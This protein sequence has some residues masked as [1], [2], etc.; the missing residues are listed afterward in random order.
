MKNW[1]TGDVFL[2]CNI[3]K[4]ICE[5]EQCQNGGT[6]REIATFRR[7]CDCPFGYD[8]R[9]CERQIGKWY[10]VSNKKMLGSVPKMSVFTNL[11]KLQRYG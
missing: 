1:Y 6:C 8:T 7:E 11:M 5:V 4:P 3:T 9:S 10:K 2:R